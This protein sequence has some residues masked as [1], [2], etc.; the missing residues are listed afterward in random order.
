VP[1]LC[2]GTA[3]AAVEETAS[4]SHGGEGD[5]GWMLCFP[6]GTAPRGKLFYWSYVYYVSKFYEL[7]DTVLL[8][9]KG[10]PLTFLHVFH[11]AFV[12]VMCF[13]W[14]QSSQSLQHI[15]LLTNTGIHVMMY[16]YYF[17]TTLGIRP[18]W[19]VLVTNGQIVQFVFSFACSVP[20]V[21]THVTSVRGG[22]GGCAGFEAWW[23]CTS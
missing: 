15:A 12:L 11:H 8:V 13:L 20:F 7:L 14:L 6:P 19:K 5:A 18:G 1:T 23:G 2:A 10:R 9:L 22:G 4:A 16:F 21:W 3:L 17:L